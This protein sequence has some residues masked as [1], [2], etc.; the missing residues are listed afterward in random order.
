VCQPDASPCIHRAFNPLEPQPQTLPP[1][2]VVRPIDFW[3]THLQATQRA[4]KGFPARFGPPSVTVSVGTPL[5]SY[6]NAYRR[7]YG[8]PHLWVIH[9]NSSKSAVWLESNYKNRSIEEKPA[10]SYRRDRRR[11]KCAVDRLFASRHAAFLVQIRYLGAGKIP[12]SP[13][14]YAQ[15]RLRQTS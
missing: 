3:I 6:G 5:R 2:L 13:H 9:E 14:W 12:G 4:T 8:P 1:K 15:N 10:K 11:Q 7:A